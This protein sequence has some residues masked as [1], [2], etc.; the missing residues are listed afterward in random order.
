MGV[1]RDISHGLVKLMLPTAQRTTR[2]HW[3]LQQQP[4]RSEHTCMQSCRPG[5]HSHIHRSNTGNT[6]S[7]GCTCSMMCSVSRKCI[8]RQK[9]HPHS[10][11]SPLRCIR[12][13][14]QDPG[15]CM[16]AHTLVYTLPC[17]TSG[18]RLRAH[19][20]AMP[21]LLVDLAKGI[22]GQEYCC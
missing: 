9:R 3:W 18:C 17:S 8:I 6:K 19:K 2:K 4:P 10:N 22:M 14:A 1:V 15:A 20:G 7:G 13:N 21:L 11:P 16:H 12:A 5:A